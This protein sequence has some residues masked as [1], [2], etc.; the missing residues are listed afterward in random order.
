MRPLRALSSPKLAAVLIAVL[1]LMSVVSVVV[2]QT[3]TAGT[4]VIDA[5][6]E[7]QP[8][9][10][11]PVLA[12][13]LDRVFVSWPYW[14]VSA[15]LAVNLAVCTFERV[16]RAKRRSYSLGSPPA[17]AV[18]V[19]TALAAPDAEAVL[20]RRMRWFRPHASD[21]GLVLVAGRWG[22]AGSVLMHAGLI[23]LVVAG[24][25]TGLTR[26][27]GEIVLTEGLGAVDEY[28]AYSRLRRIPMAGEPFTGAEIVLERMEFDYEGHVVTEA[29]AYLVTREGG[30]E[31]RDVARVN[32]PL[33]IGA[34]SFLLK[35][36]GL[37]A[38]IEI[39]GP[40]GAVLPPTMVNL[41]EARLD[42]YAD[43]VEVGEVYLDLLAI[44]DVAAPRGAAVARLL[45]PA[46]PAVIVTA[47]VGGETAVAGT[48]VLPGE[49]VELGDMTLRVTEVRRWT[50][51]NARVDWGVYAAYL[52]F[53]LAVP[54]SAL[55]FVDPDRVV[56]IA[57]SED[58]AS[59]WG[60]AGWGPGTAAASIDR[61]VRALDGAGSVTAG[62]EEERV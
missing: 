18:R 31:R 46:S 32:Y 36:S 27:E 4:R 38:G 59:V 56:R 62:H 41:G 34:K 8:W 47:T 13:G 14:I 49:S 37:A 25:L 22:F 10:A 60:S 11:V 35:D 50:R 40:E 52:A 43:S 23:V 7:G 17:D 44:P 45:E 21:G 61:A 39:T 15:L 33:R 1:L 20:T 24:V 26:F 3:R 51:F 5:W 9:I 2:P 57:L 6:R 55:R 42:G 28:D 12:L 48:L 58:G 16:R 19:P 53:A 54:G 29:R 30:R